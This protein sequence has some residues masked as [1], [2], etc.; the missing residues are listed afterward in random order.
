MQRP[1]ADRAKEHPPQLGVS[2][3]TR[4]GR[5]AGCCLIHVWPAHWEHSSWSMHCAVRAHAATTQQ[6]HTRIL[7][8][9]LRR[10]HTVTEA[11]TNN[12]LR[13]L[14]TFAFLSA[15]SGRA[16][17]VAMLLKA[18]ANPHYKNAN[19]WTAAHSAANCDFRC[20]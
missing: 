4:S 1:L 16:A 7:Q 19:G 9:S 13:T 8:Y 10:H 14:I 5:M 2:L 18:G 11:N 17:L 3:P 20:G 12:P 15:Y 6:K